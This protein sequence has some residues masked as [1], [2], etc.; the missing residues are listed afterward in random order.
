[1]LLCCGLFQRAHQVIVE[2]IGKVSKREADCVPD[3]ISSYKEAGANGDP[4]YIAAQ[5]KR[6]ELLAEFILGDGKI[7]GGFENAPL[8]P[9]ARYKVYLRGI[10]QFDGV[11]I[12]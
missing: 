9:E 8:E 2:E 5:F 11:R 7:Y 4:F 3:D 6:G 10:T 12:S 1:M